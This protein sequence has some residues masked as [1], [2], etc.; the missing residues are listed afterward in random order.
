MDDSVTPVICLRSV[1]KEFPGVPPSTVLRDFSLTIDHGEYVAIVGPSGSG[2]S[3]FLNIVGL[4]DTPSCG[5]YLLDGIDTSELREDERTALR[6]R[7]IGFVFQDFHLLPFRTAVEN[8]ALGLMYSGS[9]AR[10]RRRRARD[11][12]DRVGLSHRAESLPSTMSG[13]E[14]QRVAIARALV[15]DPQLL[16]CDE[17]TGNLDSRTAT[18]ILDL[19]DALHDGGVSILVITHDLVTAQRAARQVAIADGRVAERVSARPAGRPITYPG[20]SSA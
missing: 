6:A 11:M 7:A 9:T 1:G 10:E 20:S 19:F 15:G 4:L 8:V 16:L 17:P 12:L 14:R 3:T 2:K 13:G 18:Q 5:E